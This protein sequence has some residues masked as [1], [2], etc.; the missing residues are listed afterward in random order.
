[1]GNNI[2]GIKDV[3]DVKL[4]NRIIIT[5]ITTIKYHNSHSTI[6]IGNCSLVKLNCISCLTKI[7][8]KI[9]KQLKH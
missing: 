1:M 9:T 8:F 7:V 2:D 4:T 6:D 5:V 3:K